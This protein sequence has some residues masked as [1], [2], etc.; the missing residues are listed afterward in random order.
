MNY[1]DYR[2]VGIEFYK[3]IEELHT[4]M[5]ENFDKHS[6]LIVSNKIY[7][8]LI[9]FYSEFKSTIEKMIVINKENSPQIFSH[10]KNIRDAQNLQKQIETSIKFIEIASEN[11][12]IFDSF[13]YKDH[14]LS[15]YLNIYDFM[16]FKEKNPNFILNYRDFKVRKNS[17]ILEKYF[18][19]LF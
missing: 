14:L 1:S 12:L 3:H 16:N 4:E 15:P 5:K 7:N 13:T 8:M 19:H 2:K 17:F 11:K 18:E 9:Q 10:F 6:D